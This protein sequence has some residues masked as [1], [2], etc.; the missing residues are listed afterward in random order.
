MSEKQI[1]CQMP[2]LCIYRA[3]VGYHVWIGW[4]HWRGWHVH[5]WRILKSLGGYTHLPGAR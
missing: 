4:M 1:I 3:P 5:R 2:G